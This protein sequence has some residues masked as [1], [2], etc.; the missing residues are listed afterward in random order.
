MHAP[1]QYFKQTITHPANKRV[2]D[3]G[4]RAVSQRALDLPR[5]SG[6]K[7]HT[8][9]TTPAPP[10]RHGTLDPDAGRTE[11]PGHAIRIQGAE[12][13]VIH[14]IGDL[15]HV[16]PAQSLQPG[17]SRRCAQGV[18]VRYTNIL[19]VQGESRAPRS[20]TDGTR[21]MLQTPKLWGAFLS[22]TFPHD[23]LATCCPPL[24]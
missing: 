1:R 17:H 7:S 2:P 22:C 24:A 18:Q 10:G 16:K 14:C 12:R 9:T 6:N 11:H 15:T 23:L 20:P 13:H 4:C 19:A 5:S 21:Q 3:P 8:G